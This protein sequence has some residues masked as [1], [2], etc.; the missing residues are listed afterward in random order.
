MNIVAAADEPLEMSPGSPFVRD[1]FGARCSLA[2]NWVTTINSAGT[3]A[4][5][6]RVS[7]TQSHC[8]IINVFAPP[9]MPATFG[10][11][12]MVITAANGDELWL[13]YSGSFLS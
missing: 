2:S 4:H 6:G 13:A 8:T 10:D 9:P 12:E 7:V 1:T 5:L 11:G 3:A